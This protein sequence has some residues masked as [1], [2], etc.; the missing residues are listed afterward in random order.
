MNAKVIKNQHR[1]IRLLIASCVGYAFSVGIVAIIATGL[2]NLDIART[3]AASLAGIIAILVYPIIIVWVVATTQFRQTLITIITI[4]V[5][6]IT[7][8]P[9]LHLG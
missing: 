9:M 4:S 7:V 8:A 2:P 3:E 1:L 6:M 5:I